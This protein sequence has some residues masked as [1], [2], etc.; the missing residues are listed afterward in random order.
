MLDSTSIQRVYTKT[1][2]GRSLHAHRCAEVYGRSMYGKSSFVSYMYCSFTRKPSHVI[3]SNY[4]LRHDHIIKASIT[5]K[6]KLSSFACY[7]DMNQS[8]EK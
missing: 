3:D 5:A 7:Y 1:H 6:L 8:F 4:D 2:N